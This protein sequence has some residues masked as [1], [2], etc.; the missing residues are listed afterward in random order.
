[1]SIIYKFT[2]FKKKQ[3]KSLIFNYLYYYLKSSLNKLIINLYIE[4]LKIW[5]EVY[6]RTHTCWS[7]WLL[8]QLS[9]IAA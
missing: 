8:V 3:K 9:Y 7:M 1:M 5:E 2:S 4:V 6:Q